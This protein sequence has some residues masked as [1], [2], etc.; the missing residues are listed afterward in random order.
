MFSERKAVDAWATDD[1]ETEE[2]E[3][4]GAAVMRRPVERTVRGRRFGSVWCGGWDV[5]QDDS[6]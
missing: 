6:D 3:G 1:E 5:E 2:K 4:D